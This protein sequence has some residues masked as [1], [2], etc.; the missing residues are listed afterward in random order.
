[1][2]RTSR[3]PRR[4]IP[5]PPS[6]SPHDDPKR[7]PPEQVLPAR[8]GG[9]ETHVRTLALAQ[10]A[11]GLDVRVFCVH[12]EAGAATAA[13]MD[14]PVQV[15]RFARKASGAKLDFC[16]GLASA[17]RSVDS[18]ILHLHVPNPTMILALLRAGVRRPLAITYHSDVIKQRLRAMAF[19]PLE[20]WLYR[21]ASAVLPTSPT[22]AAGS[23]F[24][25]RYGDRTRVLPH[26]LDLAPYLDPSA[27]HRE[28]AE[29]IRARYGGPIWLGCGRM[30]YYKGFLHAVR[31]L[32]RVAGT[33]LLVGGGPDRPALEAE[34]ARLGVSDRVVFL[35]Y[36]PHYLDLTPYYLAADAFWFPSNARSEAFGLV[37]VEAMASGCPVINAA[38]PHSGV[39]WVSRHEREGLTIPLN[40]PAALAEAA[41]RLVTEPGLRDRLAE[42]ARRRAREEFDHRV[43]AERSLDI[44]RDVLAGAGAEPG[45]RAEGAKRAAATSVQPDVT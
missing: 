45:R 4:P 31:A 25:K 21:S 34:A 1:M 42:A 43:M 41:N 26:G 5:P 32:T 18:D 19:R 7:L 39:A 33:L 11:L 28:E 8:P 14:G 2:L 35:G 24:L 15:T 27:A 13:E 22:Y 10:A 23:R 44:Y 9:I 12:H 17:L 29:A 6:P 40:D 36:L 3:P 16:P 37:Q 30:V 38:I 20:R